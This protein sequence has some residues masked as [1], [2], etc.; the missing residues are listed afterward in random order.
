[1]A[2]D[3]ILLEKEGNIGILTINRPKALNALNQQVLEE[4]SQAIDV[5]TADEEI[6]VVILKGAGDKAFVAG[7]DITFMQNM[8]ALEGRAFGLLGQATFR[9]L[10]YMPKPV[11]AA[12]NG[13]A[14]GGGCELAMACDI[15]VAT[16]KSKF[17]QPEV[18]LGVIPGFAGTQ[19]L[20]RLVGKGRAKELLFTADMISAADAYRIGLV[21]H[22]V[23]EDQLMEFCKTLA[24]KIASKGQIAVRLCKAAVDEGLEM[25]VDKAMTH[26]ADLFGLCFATADQR[27]GMTAFIEK[28]KPKFIGK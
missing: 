6:F 20:P 17:G 9:K 11:I 7:A 5:I 24:N 19:R 10:E 13:F 8:T 3:T 23:P 14:L 27:E 2:W 21:N 16:E 4:L 26:E 28:R 12:I 1:M 18:G 25:D 22:V 15:R